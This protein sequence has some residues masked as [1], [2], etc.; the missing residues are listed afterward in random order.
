MSICLW[1]TAIFVLGEY[2][3]IYA[4]PPNDKYTI[5]HKASGVMD[6][7]LRPNINIDVSPHYP[8]CLKSSDTPTVSVSCQV[9][10]GNEVYNVIWE[11]GNKKHDL[12]SKPHCKCSFLSLFIFLN[13]SSFKFHI[14]AFVADSLGGMDVYEVLTFIQCGSDTE[15]VTCTFTNRCNKSKSATIHI[16]IIGGMFCFFVF[17]IH[18]VFV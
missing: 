14:N 1:L 10:S 8:R 18:S 6:I 17:C 5:T 16:H 12:I 4:E 7:S 11:K 9:E 3:C 15:N 2:S 13:E